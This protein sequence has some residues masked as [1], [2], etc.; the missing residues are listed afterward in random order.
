MSKIRKVYI[1]FFIVLAVGL[2]IFFFWKFYKPTPKPR[3]LPA[4][5]DL[6]LYLNRMV[7]H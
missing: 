4:L 7:G 2:A 5:V 3:E 1:C 6:M